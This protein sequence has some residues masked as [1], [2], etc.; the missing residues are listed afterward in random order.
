MPSKSFSIYHSKGDA[1]ADTDDQLVL[2]A[3]RT[4]I[5]CI[6]KK[7]YK[8]G[9][10]AFEL[11]N[12][13]ENE[14]ADFTKLFKTI[15]ADSKLLSKAYPATRVFI[16]NELSML[17]PLSD[18]NT[19]IAADYLNVIFGEDPFSKIRCEPLPVEPGVMN[20]YRVPEE[21]MTTLQHNSTKVTF[22]HTYSNIVKSI[23][24]DISASPSGCIYIRFYN[25]FIIVTVIRNN[26][27]QIIQ[28]FI[29]ETKEDVLYTLLNISERFELNTED[30]SIKISGM[31]DL[32]FTLYKDLIAYFKQVEVQNVDKAA[33]LLD[34]KEHPLHYFTPFFNLYENNSR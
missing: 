24:S 29:Y 33:L 25:T 8:S 11:F 16:N 21:L 1:I 9:I 4:H 18:F 31:I 10:S 19:E 2:E 13:T 15:S 23:A 20:V 34:I 6:E 32:G 14:A 7:G 28:S 22:E 30:L 27:L 12:F 5:A 26:K 17:V 3:G